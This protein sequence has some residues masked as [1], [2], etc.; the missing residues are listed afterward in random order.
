MSFDLDFFARAARAVLP[1]IPLTLLVVAF[2]LAVALPLGF[3]TAVA[4]ARRVR[5]LSPALAFL[6][7][8]MRGTPM[9]VQ[10]YV[11]YNALPLMLSAFFR[12]AGIGVNVFDIDPLLYAL[13]LFSL[14]TTATLSEVFRSALS[15]VGAG[16][17][18]AAL[19]CGLSEAQAYVR[20]VVPQMMR[21]ASAPLCNAAVEL[22]KNSSLVFYMGIRDLMGIIKTEAGIGYNYFEGYALALVIYLILCFGVQG[23]FR[24]V[25]RRAKRGRAAPAA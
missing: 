16:Q 14:N 15:T 17:M 22:L 5:A 25:E 20:I 6:V 23:I 12:K 4:R 18:E 21:A 13:F 24:L 1:G 19:T 3:L 7:S 8:L 11:I 9:I 2:S 10:I